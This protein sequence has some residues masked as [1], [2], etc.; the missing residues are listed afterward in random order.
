[1]AAAL[2]HF[3]TDWQCATHLTGL[4]SG[5]VRWCQGFSEPG[6]GSDL[7]SIATQASFDGA[8]W[9]IKGQ[10]IW[11]SEAASAEWCFLLCRTEQDL[12]QHRGLS[13]LLVPLDSSGIEVRPIK[14]AWGSDE[15]AEVWFDDALLQA[16]SLLGNRGQGWDIA[17]ALLAV[18][19][20]PADVG[21]I[22]RFLKTAGQL[23]Q[24]KPDTPRC[25]AWLDALDARVLCSLT[26][27]V[28]DCSRK[29]DGS[30][31]KLLMTK[32]DQL[33]RKVALDQS[34]WVLNDD[35]SLM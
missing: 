3:G 8:Q 26:H 15:F 25:L 32:V 28:L 12:P 9:R 14:T 21:W 18:E 10:K 17:M 33:L 22:A 34:S 13:V 24:S 20:G 11:T 2:S 19:R 23:D 31:D 35:E 29:E 16:D 1:L 6:A 5:R 27:R 4:L 30:V 7:A